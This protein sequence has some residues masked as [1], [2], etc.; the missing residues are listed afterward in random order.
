MD[1]N[2]RGNTLTMLQ[3]FPKFVKG[4]NSYA[5]VQYFE[6]LQIDNRYK[7]PNIGLRK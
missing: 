5:I 1:L 6:N 4:K 2:L 3:H 7:F